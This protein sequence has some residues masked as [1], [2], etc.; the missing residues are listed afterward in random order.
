MT[1]LAEVRK[2]SVTSGDAQ[3]SPQ[4]GGW[5]SNMFFVTPYRSRAKELPDYWSHRRDIVL[6]GT[7][8]MES[9]WASAI[10]KAITKRA[11]LG[12]SV[13][14]LKDSTVRVRRAQ[15]LFLTADAGRG[16]VPFV[17]R[18]LLDFLLT[19]NGVF[20]E[21]VHATSA[22][23]SRTLGLMHLDSLRCTRT[24]DPQ[25]PVLYRDR[26]GREHELREHQVLMFSDMPN[27]AETYN[28]VGFCAAS[29]AYLKISV[30]S[31]MEQYLVEKITGSRPK[32]LH[33][34]K[35]VTG[36]SVKDALKTGEESALARGQTHYQG[37]NIVGVM[38]DIPMELITVPISEIPDAFDPQLERQ[39]AYTVYANAIGVPV[40]DI[41]PLSGQ[42]LGT[43]TQTVILDEAAEGQGLA[44]WHKLFEHSANQYLL[45]PTTTFSFATNDM[46]DKKM[47]AEVRGLRANVRK[48]MIESGEIT[49][50][51][52]LQMAVDDG[53]VP[54]EFLPVDETQGG[55]LADDE[56]PVEQDESVI[57]A[58]QEPQ[59]TVSTNNVF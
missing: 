35:G 58:G 44:A 23:G 43:G 50:A 2:H 41:Q 30:L 13:T 5:L 22:A 11:A 26:Q 34:L 37:V 51:Q 42:G 20:I 32:A 55:S 9:M 28:G 38:G 31:A 45:P 46:R 47:D 15:Q 54:R 12:W 7:L 17:S 10:Y 4:S 8:H 48:T 52:A 14:D 19:D 29:R 3:P 16:W 40:Q 33:F 57:E 25:I 18:H 53:D 39:N 6:R 24:G 36:Q 56:K 1:D 27:A 21:V 59:E 49:P